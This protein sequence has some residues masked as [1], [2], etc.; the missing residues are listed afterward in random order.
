MLFLGSKL[1]I[2]N[3]GIIC[4]IVTAGLA[5]DQNPMCE[6]KFRLVNKN[7]FV[8][9]NELRLECGDLVDCV[10]SAPFGNWGAS[11]GDYGMRRNTAQFA[12]WK[13]KD[14]LLQ[15]NSCTAASQ[16][17]PPRFRILQSR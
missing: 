2:V 5:Q 13:L 12:G 6:V 10:H 4:L 8:A 3:L 17:S 7:R 1:R 11:A 14:G 16:F 9:N 15:W